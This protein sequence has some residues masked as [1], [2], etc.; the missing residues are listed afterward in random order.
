MRRLTNPGFPESFST[1]WE[2]MIF[3][4]PWIPSPEVWTGVQTPI[5]TRYYDWKIRTHLADFISKL[6]GKKY[7]SQSAMD[8][9]GPIHHQ[10]RA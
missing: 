5:F 9:M 3:W 6:V 2:A 4:D 7:Q 10:S 1:L 8:A